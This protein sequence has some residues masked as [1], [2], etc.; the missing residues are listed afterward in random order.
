MER[1]FEVIYQG[2]RN[3]ANFGVLADT[4]EVVLAFAMMLG[5]IFLTHRIQRWADRA[6]ENPPATNTALA[7]SADAAV[8]LHSYTQDL[9]KADIIRLGRQIDA[10]LSYIWSCY[11]G[12]GDHC[13][14]CES[15]ARLERALRQAGA[16]EWFNVQHILP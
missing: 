7:L 16:W 6:G 14:C 13:G 12:G 9:T 1:F 10:P 5:G 3:L 4:V 15:C 11:S 8:R 2:S